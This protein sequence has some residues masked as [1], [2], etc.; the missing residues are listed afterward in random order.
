M[1]NIEK[2][3]QILENTEKVPTII[4]KLFSLVIFTSVHEYVKL[5]IC[6]NKLQ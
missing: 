4:Q 3:L 2:I 6:M 1:R 5:D